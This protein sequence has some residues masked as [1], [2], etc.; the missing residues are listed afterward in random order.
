MTTQRRERFRRIHRTVRTLWVTLGILTLAALFLSVRATGFDAAI[1]RSDERVRVNESRHV[2]SF[3]PTGPMQPAALLFFPG[4][5]VE[6]TAYAPMARAVA[7]E[8][9]PVH[10]VKLP[11]R[12]APLEAHQKAV[13]ARIR[14]LIAGSPAINRWI[15]GGHSRG[16]ALAARFARDNADRIDG[17][18]LVGTSHPRRFDLSHLKL[19][20][21]KVYA[22][23]DGLASEA[24]VKEYAR[25]L[26]EGTHWV[27]IEGGNHAQFGWYGF[28]LGDQ[29]ATI[30]R[31]EQQ[32]KLVDATLAA[33]QRVS[34]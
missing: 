14:S 26:P 8:G 23:N 22:T 5:L 6:P 33:L 24:E 7:E 3:T 32:R 1:L 10:L 31:S 18:L 12:A 17:L 16:G 34:R 19:D 27:R 2:L 4:G 25:N 15:V 21:T 29:K 20:V 11:F 13:F 30:S 28:Q 9:Y